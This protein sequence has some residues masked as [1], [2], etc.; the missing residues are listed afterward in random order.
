MEKVVLLNWGECTVIDF[1]QIK[2]GDSYKLIEQKKR[3]TCRANTFMA[4]SNAYQNKH[5][6]WV[7]DHEKVFAYGLE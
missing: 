3:K 7:V 5:K 6:Q 4:K 1:K 2:K